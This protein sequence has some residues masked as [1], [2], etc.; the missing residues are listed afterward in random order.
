MSYWPKNVHE[1]LVNCL[2][3]LNLPRKSVV[4]LTDYPDMTL[5]VYRGCK[6]TTQQQQQQQLRIQ[7]LI[8][9]HVIRGF[10]VALLFLFEKHF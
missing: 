5:N 1:G 10:R 6:T 2:G 3:G 9:S 7:V 4:W 8:I